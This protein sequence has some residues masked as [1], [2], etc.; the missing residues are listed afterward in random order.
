[1]DILVLWIPEYLVE[2]AVAQAVRSGAQTA[3][4]GE[5]MDLASTFV[6]SLLIWW[7]Y[8]TVLHSSQWQATIGKKAVGIKVTDLYGN[9][10]SFSRATGRYF[11]EFVAAIPVFLGYLMVGVSSTK[12]GLHDKLAGTVV[13]WA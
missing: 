3:V 9:R 11:A 13:V 10:I 4:E 2:R 8:R 12:Q 5:I 6:L 7:L 1:L